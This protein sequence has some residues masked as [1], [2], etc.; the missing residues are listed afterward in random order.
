MMIV[1]AIITI[2]VTVIIPNL[3][4]A[5]G[6]TQVSAIEETETQISSALEM[7]YN[8]YQAYPAY[9]QY[10]TVTPTLFGG[11]GNSYYNGTPSVN[12]TPYAVDSRSW[13]GRIYLI[14]PS[15]QLDGSLMPN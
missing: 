1:V 2:L 6:T 14:G 9:G 13:S 3:F 15:I 12:G 10:V 8:D 4:H 11:S 7:Y 5:R